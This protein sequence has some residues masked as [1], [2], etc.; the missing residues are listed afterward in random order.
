MH[1]VQQCDAKEFKKSK[2]HAGGPSQTISV[3][4]CSAL[5]ASPKNPN[6]NCIFSNLDED[7][8]GTLRVYF[9][10]EITNLQTALSNAKTCCKFSEKVIEIYRGSHKGPSFYFVWS[11]S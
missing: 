1:Q 11:D 4:H 8:Y 9:F 2:V 10:S 5:H 3:S 7:I 6:H